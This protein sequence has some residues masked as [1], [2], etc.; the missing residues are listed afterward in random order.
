MRKPYPDTKPC[1][2]QYEMAVIAEECGEV[3]QLVG[4]ALRFGWDS[5]DPLKINGRTNLELLHDEVGD[6]MAAI[7]FAV[8]RGL[9]DREALQQRSFY[10][11][12]KLVE[13]APPVIGDGISFDNIIPY[14]PDED[15]S[16]RRLIVLAFVAAAL[17][18]MGV[19][20]GSWAAQNT[21]EDVRIQALNSAEECLMEQ[22]NKPDGDAS[23]CA[24]LLEVA[25][26]PVR[27]SRPE[28]I[29][30]EFDD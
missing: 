30:I 24:R 16:K 17:L 20:L 22:A 15:M 18:I 1:H 29:E 21:Q 14:T 23:E 6:V 10:K 13:T 2:H 25:G 11:R 12:R 28:V 27:E 7:D 4:K 8:E 19:V 3:T 26:S 5:H 9:L